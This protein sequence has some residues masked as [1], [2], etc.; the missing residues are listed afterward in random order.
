MHCRREPRR[1]RI[2]LH[3]VAHQRE[4]QDDHS[5][6]P[7]GIRRG[8]VQRNEAL[9]RGHFLQD[10]ERHPER[11]RGGPAHPP[12]RISPDPAEGGIQPHRERALPHP[13]SGRHVRV[14]RQAPLMK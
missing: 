6:Y 4:I 10:L 8:A 11:T 2:Q 12:G 13:H 5:V 14:G 7:D 9:Y 1:D 3:P